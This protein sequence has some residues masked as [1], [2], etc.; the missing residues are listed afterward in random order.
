MKH[1]HDSIRREKFLEFRFHYSASFRT[2]F[3]N[4]A[5]QKRKQAFTL[6]E[7]LVVI[8]IIAILAAMLLPTLSKAKNSGKRAN[9]ISNLHQ[10]G[11]GLLMYA[12]E[13][14]GNIPRGNQPIWWQTLVRSVGGRGTDYKRVG[15]Y[16]CPSYPDKRQLICYV[17]NSWR[18]SSPL[19]RVGYEIIGLTK[20]SRF[21]RPSDTVY[22]ADNE[23]GSWRPI[24]TELAIIGSDELNDVWNPLHLPY[25]SSP[26]A[27]SPERRVAAARH[28][29]GPVLLFF[30]GH[31][32]LKKAK[33]IVVDD[34]RE[35]R[36]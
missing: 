3:S 32:A 27:L 29:A 12:D 22:L 20:M 7:L 5:M 31:A 11:I 6:I 16:K 36:R 30:D 19:D 28:G 2:A 9:C 35:E 13:N 25:G 33:A 17:A 15:I 18:F 10:M 14:D 1:A 24:I 34:W 26:N 4:P 21:Q 8:A 23:N